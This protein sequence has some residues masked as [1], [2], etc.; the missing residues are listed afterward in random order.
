MAPRIETRPATPDRWDDLGAVFGSRGDAAWCWCQFFRYGGREWR[1]ST[2]EV[3]RER[4]HDQVFAGAGPPP[5]V[6]GYADGEPVGWC[7][8]GPKA[9]YS[10]L[11]RSPVARAVDRPPDSPSDPETVWA[12][13]CF[14]VSPRARRRGLA[15]A[16]LEG[17]VALARDHGA[18]LVEGYPV[19][20][21]RRSSISSAE[22]YHG[23]LSVFLR[24]GFEEV[25]RPYPARAAVRRRLG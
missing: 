13:T 15:D 5:G 8:I 9:A 16:L 3:N 6:I 4:M 14:Q 17:A 21:S 1:G 19:D 22:L 18:T 25:A 2:R 11:R 24:A 12:V 20:P 7:A 23:P 10:R